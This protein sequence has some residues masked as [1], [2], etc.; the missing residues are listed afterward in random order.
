[1]NT[2]CQILLLYFSYTILHNS[3]NI[4]FQMYYSHIEGKVEFRTNMSWKDVVPFSHGPQGNFIYGDFLA[5][6]LCHF[7]KLI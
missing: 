5:L 4:K 7:L 3:S 6:T 2:I 1:M